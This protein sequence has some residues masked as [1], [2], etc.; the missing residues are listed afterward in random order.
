MDFEQ[1]FE[2]RC[3]QVATICDDERGM[4]MDFLIKSHLS[5]MFV[6]SSYFLFPFY[7]TPETQVEGAC[8]LNL[9]LQYL[10]RYRKNASRYRS[11]NI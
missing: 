4:A 8:E 3:R 10:Y 2:Y 9:M 5:G 1:A 6:S 11:K 7:F